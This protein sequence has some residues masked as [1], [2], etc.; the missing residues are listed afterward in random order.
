ML[1]GKGDRART[2][3][4]DDSAFEFIDRWIDARN[5]LGVGGSC[6]L[7]CTKN[8]GLIPTS[9]I[10]KLLPRLKKRAGIEKRIH[11]HGF[12]HT[13]AC[14]MRA[15]GRDIGY[16]SKQLGHEHVST[17]STYLDNMRPEGLIDVMRRRKIDRDL[18]FPEEKRKKKR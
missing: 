1:H 6:P 8:G 5:K 10:R 13:M 18:F 12:R 9:Y 7:F 11:A 17:T 14:E 3:A 4:M 15:E 2:V 16:I